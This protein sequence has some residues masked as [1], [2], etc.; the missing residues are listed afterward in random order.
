MVIASLEE[1]EYS[2]EETVQ[3]DPLPPISEGY[4]EDIVLSND[5][6]YNLN[7]EGEG[8]SDSEKEEESRDEDMANWDLN[9]MAQGPLALLDN[10]H[11]MPEHPEKLLSNF[12]PN[13]KKKEEGYIDVFYMHLRMLEVSYYD[14]ACMIFPLKLEGRET[15]F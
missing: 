6:F 12:D 1:L 5:I 10:L 13:K 15:T 2:S 7:S 11:K 14:V 3:Q 8:S 4:E 9:W